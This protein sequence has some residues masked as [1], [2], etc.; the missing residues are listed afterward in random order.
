M[1][2]LLALDLDGTLL[3]S[4]NRVTPYTL[5]VLH[6]AVDTGIKL[7]VATGR[8]TYMFR[9]L[10]TDVPINA[11]QITCNGAIIYDIRDNSIIQQLLLPE[12]I[13]ISLLKT[14]RE[15]GLYCCYYSDQRLYI[16]AALAIQSHHSPSPQQR[17]TN[18]PISISKDVAEYASLPCIKI[19][20]YGDEYTLQQKRLVIKD[21]LGGQV[22]IT[23]TAENCL[24]FL[25][26]HVSKANA[27]RTILNNYGI[28]AEDVI[29]FGD[30]P[31]DVEMLQLAGV[32]VA[33]AN[34]HQEVKEAANYITQS[35]D[36]DGVALAIERFL[37]RDMR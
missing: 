6:R 13:I 14:L 35:N 3:T 37:F 16:D 27:L 31:N 8:V 21:R 36:Q 2:R 34:A 15:L 20:A 28:A 12:E 22:Y 17:R 11:P 33:V 1:Y 19:A 26:P 29:A 30:N 7:V 24:E 10:V 32:G 25:H 5:A 23:Q 4:S 18:V 9:S